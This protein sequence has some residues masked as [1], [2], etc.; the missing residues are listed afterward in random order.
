MYDITTVTKLY[1][2]AL[3]PGN[4]FSAGRFDVF[5]NAPNTGHTEGTY[6]QDSWKLSPRY[7][8]DYGL[9]ADAFQ[10]SSTQ[11]ARRSSC[12]ARA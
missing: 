11:F 2:I 8:L 9:R 1:D 4:Y 6:L 10:L 5:D 12:S 7:E 3:Q